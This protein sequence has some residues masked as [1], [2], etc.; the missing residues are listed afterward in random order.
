MLEVIPASPPPPKT[1]PTPTNLAR[2]LGLDV[3]HLQHP[4]FA[5][6]FGGWKW[7]QQLHDTRANVIEQMVNN[8]VR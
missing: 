5:G 7:G 6:D 4:H 8:L 3:K 1:M 2:I